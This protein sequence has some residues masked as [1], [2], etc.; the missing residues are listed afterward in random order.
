MRTIIFGCGPAGLMAAAGAV[1][2]GSDIL[3]I[4]KRRKSELFGAQYLHE[5]IAHYTN[6]ADV[7][8]VR[9]LLE[10][11]IVDYR[12]KVYGRSWGG[13]VS[14]EDLEQN[15]DA[16][17]IRSTYDR[18][19]DD[20]NQHVMHVDDLTP[21]VVE[22]IMC[23][24]PDALFINSVP[25]QVLCAEGHTFK[26]TQI[27]AAGDAPS[28]G[29]RLQYNCPEST[30]LC[31]GYSEVSWYRI[32][33]IFDHKTVEWSSH[34]LRGAPP[35]TTAAEVIK[36]LEHNCSCFPTITHVGRYG[37][38]EKGVL[39]HTAYADAGAAVDRA[40]AFGVQS[41]LPGVS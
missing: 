16:W 31:N 37:R 8:H 6:A 26:A 30:V 13:S 1:H 9:Y 36:P 11:N 32:S 38:W 33:N 29:I 19:W 21:W 4:S 22:D 10:G 15:H 18:L 2:A 14:P 5:P 24:H 20:F 23:D 41:T 34:T 7:T 27:W 25:R 17:D 28:R 35:V 3:I 39:S 12:N 40:R